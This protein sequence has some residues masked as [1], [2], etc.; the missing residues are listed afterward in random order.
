MIHCFFRPHPRNLRRDAAGSGPVGTSRAWGSAPPPGAVDAHHA[1]P[2]Q[3]TIES[4]ENRFLQPAGV[5]GSG[6][7]HY[8]LLKV[9]GDAG[10]RSRAV[11]LR[12][13]LERRRKKEGELGNVFLRSRWIGADEE[14]PGEQTV[15]GI[16][17][18]HADRERVLRICS[19]Q[20]IVDE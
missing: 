12:I 16:L 2:G 7:D 15:P 14:L 13:G 3:E 9:D 18:Y 11:D 4:R 19:A 5:L 17:R 8:P 1:A 10:L 6:N 20:T